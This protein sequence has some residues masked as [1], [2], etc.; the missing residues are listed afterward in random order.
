MDDQIDSRDPHAT[1]GSPV[2]HLRERNPAKR[3]GPKTSE[4]KARVRHN[5]TRFGIHS[6]DPA[7]PGIERLEDWK[8][9][10]DGIIKSLAP[11][12][13]LEMKLAER[14]ALVLWR[15]NRVIAYEQA[16]YA[17]AN[18]NSPEFRLPVGNELDKIMRYEAHLGRQFYQAKHELEALQKQRQGEATPLARVDVTG[19]EP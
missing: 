17:R 11:V 1:P 3:P 18:A 10:R 8:A 9:H 2:E 16:E 5:P 15:L 6:A 19:I 4:G 7:I 13:S 12:G 14:V